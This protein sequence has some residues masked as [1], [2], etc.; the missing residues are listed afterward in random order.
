[1]DLRKT[2]LLVFALAG[3][4]HSQGHYEAKAF[5]HAE[6]PSGPVRTQPMA[7]ERLVPLGLPLARPRGSGRVSPSHACKLGL[8]WIVSKRRDSPYSSGR[9]RHWI[10]SKNPNAP[11]V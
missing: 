3:F 2:I 8:E 1:I 6:A 4:S 10:K 7:R 5:G 9:S 11:A